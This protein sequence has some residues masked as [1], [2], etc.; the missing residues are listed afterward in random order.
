MRSA[1]PQS[2]QPRVR[3]ARPFRI[4]SACADSA[5]AI[6]VRPNWAATFSSLA[7]RFTADPM[8]GE[9]E[10]SRAADIAVKNL[11]QVQPEP[12]AKLARELRTFSCVHCVNVAPSRARCRQY[13]T[14]HFINIGIVGGNREDRQ[15]S[16]WSN[17][18]VGDAPSTSHSAMSETRS[19]SRSCRCR[20]RNAD[21]SKGC[22]MCDAAR[23]R[24]TRSVFE[25][26]EFSEF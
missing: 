19:I 13:A 20:P 26:I 5:D 9:V 1:A 2:P 25:R 3:L 21:R 23:A 6:M 7:T 10:P 22:A 12:K 4:G 16:V 18:A 8:P 14:A 11:L 15:Q 24:A 17:A